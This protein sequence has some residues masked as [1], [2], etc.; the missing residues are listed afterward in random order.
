LKQYINIS[1]PSNPAEIYSNFLTY[2]QYTQDL[3]AGVRSD[4]AYFE[5][6]MLYK[7]PA[8]YNRVDITAISNEDLKTLLKSFQFNNLEP[9]LSMPAADAEKITQI[10]YSNSF[11][12]IG[13]SS[14]LKDYPEHLHIPIFEHK[15]YTQIKEALAKN[16][17]GKMTL[18]SIYRNFKDLVS[19]AMYTNSILGIDEKLVRN[20]ATVVGWILNKGELD[21]NITRTQP[22]EG[23]FCDNVEAR[24][25]FVGSFK[26]IGKLKTSGS[27]TESPIYT[28][29]VPSYGKSCG[30]G[31][32]HNHQRIAINTQSVDNPVCITHRNI[33]D[34]IFLSNVIFIHHEFLLFHDAYLSENNHFELS[35]LIQSYAKVTFPIFF[36]TMPSWDKFVNDARLNYVN[37]LLAL[38][39]VMPV[40]FNKEMYKSIYTYPSM[41]KSRKKTIVTDLGV[42]SHIKPEPGQKNGRVL[43][44]GFNNP[45]KGYQEVVDYLLQNTSEKLLI[46]GKGSSNVKSSDPNRV[47]I[48]DKYM[49]EE[50]M[51]KTIRENV[52]VIVCNRS[53]SS[54]SSSASYRFAMSTGLPVVAS[55]SIAHSSLKDFT[56]IQ[57]LEYFTSM[58]VM[59]QM[60]NDI[61]QEVALAMSEDLVKNWNLGR[62]TLEVLKT[63]V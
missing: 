44:M 52:K 16:E 42:Y 34:I 28:F 13:M 20:L 58:E 6:A 3:A 5:T 10:A 2:L 25:S 12:I 30:I 21:F 11:D 1:D 26:N 60:I 55:D 35:D 39:N 53:P 4:M 49:E 19:I 50:E 48:I 7:A 17:L 59:V 62:T 57:G 14:A 31:D 22:I 46:I 43:L 61:D 56:G 45:G 37:D 51:L 63:F 8:G 15:A 54:T 47:W 40:V 23:Y 36:H 41:I 9:Y 29:L 32:Y 38:K 24:P 27:V 18:F 33:D